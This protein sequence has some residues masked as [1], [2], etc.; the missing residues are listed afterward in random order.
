MRVRVHCRI[1][2]RLGDILSNCL[3]EMLDGRISVVMSIHRDCLDGNGLVCADL[4][5]DVVL[6]R[7]YT[8]GQF[9]RLRN[10]NMFQVYGWMCVSHPRCVD[11]DFPTSCLALRSVYLMEAN[12]RRKSQKSRFRH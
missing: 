9:D 1:L 10:G 11:R 5:Q 8:D 4:Q 3:I 2:V 12:V 6:G 7:N